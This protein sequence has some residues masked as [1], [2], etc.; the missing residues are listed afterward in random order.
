MSVTMTICCFELQQGCSRRVKEG[1]GPQFR[2]GIGKAIVSNKKPRR[3]GI[4]TMQGGGVYTS[5]I[6]RYVQRVKT[7]KTKKTVKFLVLLN[8]DI[9]S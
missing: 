7:K 3:A 6:H 9:S 2:F 1:P 8:I 5:N 4:E